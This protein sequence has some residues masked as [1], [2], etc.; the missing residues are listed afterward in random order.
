M[1]PENIRFGGG[2]ADTMLHPI[3]A[4]FLLVAIA[5]MFVLPRKYGIVALL[6]GTFV[7]PLGQVIVLAG[8]HFPVLRV[9]ILLGFLC[10]AIGMNRERSSGKMDGIGRAV[11]LWI[12]LGTV[13]W[14]IQFMEMGAFIKAAG[15]L[16]D[17]LAGYWV[18][19]YFIREKEDVTRTIKV[20]AYIS[21]LMGVC[22]VIEQVT[23]FN[24]FTLVGGVPLAPAMREGGVRAQGAFAIYLDA[25]VFGAILIPLF[26]WLWS[27]AGARVIAFMGI[28][29]ATAMTLA[30]NSSTPVLAYASGIFALCFWPLRGRMRAIRWGVVLCLVALHLV[31]NGPVWALIAR[32]DVV[33]SSSGWHRYALVDNFIR[34]FR[35]WWLIGYP[36]Y[37]NWGW[38]MWD[39]CNEYVSVGLT[40]GLVT[41]VCFILVLSRSFGGLG[42]ARKLVAGDRKQE[43]FLWCLGS[44]L[45]A[46]VVGFFGVAYAAQMSMAFFAF[47]AMISVAIAEAEPKQAVESETEATGTFLA[48]SVPDPVR[49]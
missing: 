18:V 48:S 36:N 33:G 4:V 7:I 35:D 9:L 47:L 32:V 34:H 19:R 6:L 22:M 24:V 3:V 45:F 30:S 46:N 37:N 43:W 44:C 8:V 5:L 28:V 17:G 10:R 14:S 29:G 12:V 11:T 15:S 21:I 20:F 16:I 2:S 26:I 41:F 49:V 39:L 13:L 40:G 25:G 27:G 1:E 42:T 38:D 31:M 23:H